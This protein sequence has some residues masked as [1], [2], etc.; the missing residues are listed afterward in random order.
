MHMSLSNGLNAECVVGLLFRFVLATPVITARINLWVWIQR[1]ALI[2]FP[3][4]R[5]HMI[6]TARSALQGELF[7]YAQGR[8]AFESPTSSPNKCILLGGLS[9]GLWPVPY[10]ADLES[11]I[12]A[13]G[14]S[15]VQPILSSSYTGF[16]H[17]SLDRDVTELDELI[18]HLVDVRGAT[19]VAMVGHSTGAQD[20]VH[21]IR[22]G[23]QA[24]KVVAAALQAPVSDREAATIC[25][26]ADMDE[27]DHQHQLNENLAVATR[28]RDDKR[29]DELMP[30]AAFWAPI[31][32]SRYLDLTVR[33][34][35]DDYFSSDYTDTE[36]YERLAHLQT[37]RC[38]FACSGA[39][40]Y[41]PKTVDIPL[42]MERLCRAAAGTMAESSP[43]PGLYLPTGNH[44]LSSRDGADAL[45]FVAAFVD[46]L[47]DIV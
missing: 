47:K 16:G 4:Y 3:R 28:M 46:L 43:Q 33:G 5:S 36:L 13:I 20:I 17:G 6:P 31:T 19:R 22:H 41:N 15:L 14:W 8:A 30:R 11:A 12:G 27:Q 38:L 25:H 35:R 40:E 37:T 23:R 10:T 45:S 32:A 26:D 1:C 44:N 7:L 18:D 34:G 2:C 21:F 24:D 9:D 42:L 39:D 29:L